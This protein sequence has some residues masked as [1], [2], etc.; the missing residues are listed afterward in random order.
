LEKT[1]NFRCEQVLGDFLS[2]IKAANPPEEVAYSRM[3]NVLTAHSQ[4]DNIRLQVNRTHISKTFF[5]Y[6]SRLLFDR[7]VGN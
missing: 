3:I 5:K 1:F 4:S 7:R 2:D 6:S